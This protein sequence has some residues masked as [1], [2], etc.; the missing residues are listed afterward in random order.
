MRSIYKA[1]TMKIITV[2][3]VNQLSNMNSHD[4]N[5]IIGIKTTFLI[6]T[7]KLGTCLILIHW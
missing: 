4:F 3:L 6:K 2:K 7:L 5:Y 1:H